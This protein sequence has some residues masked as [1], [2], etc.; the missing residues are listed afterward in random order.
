MVALKVYSLVFYY[1]KPQN[2]ETNQYD[3]TQLRLVHKIF[4][5]NVFVTKTE[6]L[7][8]CKPFLNIH[9]LF[10]RRKL[11]DSHIEI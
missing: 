7:Y 5:K 11:V 3:A 2:N 9:E 4:S 6:T 10:G 8:Q 1:E